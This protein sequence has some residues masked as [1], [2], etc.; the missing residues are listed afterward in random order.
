MGFAVLD[1][2]CFARDCLGVKAQNKFKTVAGHLDC[3]KKYL[4]HVSLLTGENKNNIN[5]NNLN[6][7]A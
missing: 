3:P 5:D 7:L 6:L 4:S 2:V 1:G